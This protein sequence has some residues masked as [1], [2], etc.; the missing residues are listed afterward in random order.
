[1]CKEAVR[2]KL[3]RVSS[4][5]AHYSKKSSSSKVH[6]SESPL[7]PLTLTTTLTLIISLILNP[8]PYSS[9]VGRICIMEFLNN[10]SSE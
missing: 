5:W 10:G 1:M 8:K 7:F 9:T 6:Y 2:Q 4:I 3:D